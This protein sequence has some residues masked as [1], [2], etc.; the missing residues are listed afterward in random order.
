MSTTIEIFEAYL[1]A[2]PGSTAQAWSLRA[3][4]LMHGTREP[5]SLTG[6]DIARYRKARH[7]LVK[8]GTLRRELGAVAA[9]L[10]WGKR[11]KLWQGELVDIELPAKSAPRTVVLTADEEPAFYQAALGYVPTKCAVDGRLSRVARFVAIGLDT[12][13]RKEAIETLTWGQVDLVRGFIDFELPG[14]QQSAKRRAKTPIS[15]R[16]RAVLERAAGER[17]GPW[18]LDH[19]G[20]VRKSWGNFLKGTPWGHITPHDMRRTFVTLAIEAGADIEAVALAV[21]DDP[22]TLRKHYAHLS[23]GYLASQLGKRWA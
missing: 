10:A 15:P 2:R 13:A 18:V 5:A 9:A 19:Q 4:G 7:G 17:Q 14:R 8:S 22:A 3:F 12:G 6:L 23:P 16:L 21:G 1:D 20:D 11:Q